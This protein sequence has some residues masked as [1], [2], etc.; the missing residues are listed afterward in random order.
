MSKILKATISILLVILALAV[1]KVLV[2]SAPTAKR[3][4]PPKMAP[5]VETVPLKSATE[6]VQ[7]KLTG[8]V[9]PAQSIKLQSRVSGEIISRS[10]NFI[11][12]GF[13]N[14]GKEILTIDPIDYEL[15]LADAEYKLEN[16]RFAYMQ[17][18]GRQ[19]V[20]KREW[21]LLKSADATELEK[22]LSLR[23]PHLKAQKAELKAAE[24][25]LKKAEINLERTKLRAPFNALVLKR[26][27]HIG[28]Q[29]SL[30]TE[31][32]ELVGTDAYWIMVSIAVDRLSWV[33]VPG[34]PVEIV[35]TSGAVRQGKVIKLMGSLE[36]KGRMARLLVEVNDPLCI[37][38]ENADKKPLLLGEYV[39]VTIDGRE[40]K[41]VFT[42]PRS[43]L[44]E[45]SELWI[46]T[47][48]EQLAV[49]K[50]EVLWRDSEQVILRDG[51]TD[52][53]LLIISDINIPIHGMDVNTGKKE[54]RGKENALPT[55]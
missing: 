3:K 51:L 50:I 53:D 26:N 6:I 1:A 41:K 32:A 42:I 30:Q 13:L 38:P 35:S 24:A 10:P 45:N 21:E 46:A 49:R 19:D 25:S 28:S 20:A 43:A 52:G 14:K 23:K 40:L 54:M 36:E 44:R 8:T 11:D 37:L 47:Q 48:E 29:A 55:Q 12:G 7:L 33:T 18:L 31:L 4:K 22:K 2:N 17:E 34:S 15:A 16:A 9:T 39:R 5:L 27:V